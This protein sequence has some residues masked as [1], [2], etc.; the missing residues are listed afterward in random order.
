MEEMKKNGDEFYTMEELCKSQSNGNER[1][2]MAFYWFFSSSLEFVCGADTWRAL[3][4]K[5]LVSKA[6]DPTTQQNIVTPSNKAFGLILF[7]NYIDKWKRIA[8]KAEADKGLED[9]VAGSSTCTTK[10]ETE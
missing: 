7:K 2:P 5:H 1:E 4:H 6:I 8:N 10:E 9:V 3:R